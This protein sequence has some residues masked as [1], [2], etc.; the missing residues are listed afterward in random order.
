LVWGGSVFYCYPLN[1]CFPGLGWMVLT[2]WTNNQNPGGQK[3]FM[4]LPQRPWSLGLG[5]PATEFGARVFLA[6]SDA[7]FVHTHTPFSSCKGCD[8]PLALLFFGG[9]RWPLFFRRSWG[10]GDGNFCRFPGLS[11]STHEFFCKSGITTW[12]GCP[13]GFLGCVASYPGGCRGSV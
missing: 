12:R 4:G 3:M 13:L 8:Q 11:F 10:W 6:R 5:S 7:Q 9:L 2:G 1:L